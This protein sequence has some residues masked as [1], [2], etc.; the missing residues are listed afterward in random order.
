MNNSL[1]SEQRDEEILRVL[2]S[3]PESEDDYEIVGYLVEKNLTGSKVQ[4]SSMRKNHGEVIAVAWRGPNAAGKDLIHELRTR[5]E[6]QQ[7]EALRK[8]QADDKARKYRW[9]IPKKGSPLVVLFWAVAAALIT[10]A[11]I[12]IATTHLGTPAK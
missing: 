6:L 1:T 8:Q 10:T 7:S 11:I 2:T 5:A 3:G 12:H 4:I 9:I